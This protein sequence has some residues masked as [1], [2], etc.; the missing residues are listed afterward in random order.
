MLNYK[1]N[2]HTLTETKKKEKSPSAGIMSKIV[3]NE[4]PAKFQ[5][6]FST[7]PIILVVQDLILEPAYY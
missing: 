6:L 2:F 3:T 1:V 7:C 5:S 4:I